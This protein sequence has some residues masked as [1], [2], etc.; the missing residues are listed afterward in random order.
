MEGS[1]VAKASVFAKATTDK[2]AGKWRRGGTVISDQR[3]RRDAVRQAQSL[4][5]SALSSWPKGEAEA[6]EW[7]AELLAP[8]ARRKYSPE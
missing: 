4:S 3:R 5:H 1:A 2:M 6:E 7:D 8:E